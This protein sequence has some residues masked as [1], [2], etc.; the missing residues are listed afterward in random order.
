MPTCPSFLD[1]PFQ[2]RLNIYAYSGL[3]RP[4]PI[5]IGSTVAV[6]PDGSPSEPRCWLY[7]D[8]DSVRRFHGRSNHNGFIH[9]LG[10]VCPG[11]PTALLRVSRAI[12]AEAISVFASRNKFLLRAH[13]GPD[14]IL[15]QTMSGDIL[16]AMTSL[17]VRLNSWPCRRGHSMN[18]DIDDCETCEICY[19]PL[20]QADPAM[21]ATTQEGQDLIECWTTICKRMSLVI[22]PGRLKLAFFCDVDSIETARQV[23]D[24]LRNLPTLDQCTIRL[25]REKDSNLRRLAEDTS[26]EM[27]QKLLPIPGPFPFERLPRELRHRILSFTDLAFGKYHEDYNAVRISG[28]KLN[29]GRAYSIN[30]ATITDSCCWECTDTLVD[31]C[32]PKRYAAYSAPC[33]CRQLPLL[34]LFSVS[35]HMFEDAFQVFYSNNCFE[36]PHDPKYALVFLTSQSKEA[37]SLIRRLR[38][39]FHLLDVVQ[40]DCS[41]YS[42]HWQSLV[43]FIKDNFN[44]PNLSIEINTIGAREFLRGGDASRSIIYD[45]YCDIWRAL[46]LMPNLN[47]LYFENH[48][49]LGP[50]PY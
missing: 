12:Y 23:I 15:L 31:C 13:T 46:H 29:M 27:T 11:I 50:L 40:W 4:C 18:E 6:S 5:D 1:L 10:C 28:C 44:V 17:L 14:L 42:E 2:A 37:L 39:V 48:P 43:R 32:C 16:S 7:P 24:P 38:F 35:K 34:D 33:V 19:T 22:R 45:M 8:S 20:S 49:D 36:F 41:G 26:D 3:L 21:D 9:G 30:D 47:D 25:G